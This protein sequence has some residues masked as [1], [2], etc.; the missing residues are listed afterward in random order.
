MGFDLKRQT[1][2]YEQLKEE[3]SRLNS[4]FDA[5]LKTQGVTADFLAGT[6][7]DNPPPEIKER[8]DAAKASAQRAGKERAGRARTE[9]AAQGAPAPGHRPGALRL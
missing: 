6:D 1:Q 3:F 9:Q 4:R 7:V 8:L 2:E 5:L